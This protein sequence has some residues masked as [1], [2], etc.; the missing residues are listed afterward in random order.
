MTS[1][2]ERLSTRERG[3]SRECS[4]PLRLV[5]EGVGLYALCFAL[6]CALI[7]ATPGFLGNDDYYH[8]RISD[9]IIVQGRL[10]VDF[11]WLPQTILDRQRFVDHH[12]LYHIYLAP[13]VHWGGLTGAKLAQSAVAAGVC[14]AVWALLRQM[15]VRRS[16]LWTLGIFALSSPFLFRLL[17]I[18]TQGA[19][20]MLLVLALLI[21]F[22]RSHRWMLVLSFT[23]AWLYDG[24][25]LMPAFA[26]LYAAGT[27]MAERR[28][29][30]QPVAYAAVG[31]ALGLVIN[32][33]F[34]SNV[35]FIVDHLTAKVDF[36]AGVPVGS[37]WYPYTTGSLLINSGGALLALGA[38]LLRPGFGGKRDRYKN[39]LLLIALLTLFMLFRSRRFIEYFPLFALLYCAASWGRGETI[40]TLL[41]WGKLLV[42]TAVVIAALV[43]AFS[44][45]ADA[46]QTIA[47]ND[48]PR[49]FAGASNWLK[50]NTPTGTPVFQTDWDDFTRLFYY[51]TANT[52]LVGL[53]PTYLQLANPE[54][55]EWWVAI[56]RGEVDQPSGMIREVFGASYVVSDSKHN[57]FAE[58]ANTDPDMRLVYW[59][60]AS[61]VWVIDPAE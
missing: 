41:R 50:A 43:F 36:E 24:F 55:W 3:F 13:W 54:L 16:A 2:T 9:E 14:A 22:R 25:V 20:L 37:E 30:W 6:F 15:G 12:L 5:A 52:Y 4:I 51:N 46:R 44:T 48:D 34:P 53:D 57:A 31:T 23:F 18:R 19:A 8:A 17:M 28:F 39:V 11:P 49:W 10:R 35:A 38:A 60:S 33:Y 1:I 7:F 40:I 26:V 32:P 45:L 42:Q 61:R 56:T 21:M 27:W 29:E 59:D 47:N 58:R